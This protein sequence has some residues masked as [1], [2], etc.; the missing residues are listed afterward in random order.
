MKPHVKI[1]NQLKYLKFCIISKLPQY[2]VFQ[3]VYKRFHFFLFQFGKA[4]QCE[5]FQVFGTI[6][7]ILNR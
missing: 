2:I 4:A 7:D 1:L 6:S 5:N 3:T